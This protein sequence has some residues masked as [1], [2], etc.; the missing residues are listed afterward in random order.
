[1]SQERIQVQVLHEGYLSVKHSSLK[2]QKKRWVVIMQ[3]VTPEQELKFTIRY[4]KHDDRKDDRGMAVLKNGMT[5]TSMRGAA[6]K[7][8]DSESKDIVFKAS[9]D[10]EKRHWMA[11]VREALGKGDSFHVQM[12]SALS[13]IPRDHVL[14]VNGLDLVLINPVDGLCMRSWNIVRLHSF[15][16]S[17]PLLWLQPCQCGNSSASTVYLTLGSGS[18]ACLNVF[19]TIVR[20]AAT[21]SVQGTRNATVDHHSWTCFVIDHSYHAQR[22]A[23]PDGRS[24]FPP[25]PN[26]QLSASLPDDVF[27]MLTRSET[28]DSGLG[29]LYSSGQTTPDGPNQNHRNGS[30][31][32]IVTND[33]DFPIQLRKWSDGYLSE[34]ILSRNEGPPLPPRPNYTLTPSPTPRR[35]EFLISKSVSSEAVKPKFPPSPLAQRNQGMRKCPS[36]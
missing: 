23:T 21:Q 17:G 12:S 10:N 16:C 26:Q 11:K 7:I 13:V 25:S 6:F 24:R 22:P 19:N 36:S 14:Y 1:M 2:G 28:S 20:K 5:V 15:G 29:S 30:L 33:M 8:S 3:S 4:Y 35:K 27:G 32:N 18:N 31:P 9:T 34:Q